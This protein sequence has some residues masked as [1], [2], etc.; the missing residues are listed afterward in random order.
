MVYEGDLKKSEWKTV[1]AHYKRSTC[2]T[3]NRNAMG[4][5]I[6]AYLVLLLQMDLA[7]RGRLNV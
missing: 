2:E 3:V 1:L 7:K 5:V 4:D 6:P